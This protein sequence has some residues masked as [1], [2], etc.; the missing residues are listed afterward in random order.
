MTLARLMSRPAGRLARILAGA[1]LIAVGVSLGG[2][3]LILAAVGLVPIAAGVLNICLIAP[4][5]GAPFAGS[6]TRT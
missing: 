6:R 5:I 4:L 1:V 2:A 3:W